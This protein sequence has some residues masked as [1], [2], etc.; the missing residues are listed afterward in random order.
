MIKQENEL[1]TRINRK[2][3]RN[4]YDAGFPVFLLPCKVRLE[5]SWVSLCEVKKEEINTISSDGFNT[6]VARN[7]SFETIENAF[8][9]YNCNYLETGKYPAYYIEKG[10]EV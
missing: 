4:L 1:F 9:Y 10:T 5:N 8:N 3:A 6:I 7:D 2:Q